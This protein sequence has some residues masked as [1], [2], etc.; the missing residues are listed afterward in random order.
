MTRQSPRANG[1]PDT[2]NQHPNRTHTRRQDGSTEAQAARWLPDYLDGRER[3]LGDP[4]MTVGD[5]S[6]VLAAMVGDRPPEDPTTAWCPSCQPPWPERMATY[7]R[8]RVRPDLSWLCDWC[9]ATGDPI[10]EGAG[11]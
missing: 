8:V 1:G 11:R 9:G 3:V 6:K 7:P 5:I 10:L 4:P 2:C